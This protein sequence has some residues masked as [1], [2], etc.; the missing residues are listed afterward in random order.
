VGSEFTREDIATK[1]DVPV[2]EM[3]PSWKAAKESNAIEKVRTDGGKRYFGL[4]SE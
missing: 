1:L 4:K 2:S 3:R